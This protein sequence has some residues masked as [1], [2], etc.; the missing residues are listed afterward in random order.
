M[1][2]LTTER[3]AGVSPFERHCMVPDQL[4]SNSEVTLNL[5]GVPSD[6]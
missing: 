6:F 4:E 1:D 3:R 2:L 5:P